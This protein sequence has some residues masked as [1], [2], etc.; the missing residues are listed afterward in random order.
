M[1]GPPVVASSP[2][3]G[4]GR[5]RHA[6]ADGTGSGITS[7]GVRRGGGVSKSSEAERRAELQL[8]KR[9]LHDMLKRYEKDFEATHGRPVRTVEDIAVVQGDYDR[10]KQLKAALGER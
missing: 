4:H 6:S 5:S 2:E 8:E 7:G 3:R 10:Y 1:G 9:H